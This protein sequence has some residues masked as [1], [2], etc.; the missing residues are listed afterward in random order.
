M[1]L[2]DI[3]QIKFDLKNEGYTV[4]YPITKTKYKCFSDTTVTLTL[5]I[6]TEFETEFVLRADIDLFNQ[7]VYL[8]DYYRDYSLN[9]L[10]WVNPMWEQMFANEL[11][12]RQE[13]STE[14]PYGM[15]IHTCIDADV[16]LSTIHEDMFAHNENDEEEEHESVELELTDS[17]LATIAR[18][19]HVKD[20][21]INDFINEALKIE[22]DH[23]IPD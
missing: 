14:T 16:I 20:M 4:L 19:A 22:L 18:A 1:N 10:R 3:M 9:V 15:K 7:T 5:L 23:V 11:F 2:D 6:E 17:E 12:E 8:V 13:D 21:T